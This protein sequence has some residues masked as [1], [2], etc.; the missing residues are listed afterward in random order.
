MNPMLSIYCHLGKIRICIPGIIHIIP[1]S[2]NVFNSS[3]NRFLMSSFKLPHPLHLPFSFIS[4]RVL[5]HSVI[6]KLLLSST[7]AGV[8]ALHPYQVLPTAPLSLEP[9]QQALRARADILYSL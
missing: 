5:D 8:K 3:S 1:K 6:H 7:S 2:I 4:L 9:T